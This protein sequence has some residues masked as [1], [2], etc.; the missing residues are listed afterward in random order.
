[1][2]V[3]HL[4]RL[5]Q[6]QRRL[7]SRIATGA[8]VCG[9][10]L[11]LA[12]RANA[13]ADPLA[14]R[15]VTVEAAGEFET[16][17]RYA[18]TV[19]ARRASQLGFTQPG[20]VAEVLVDVGDRVI[21]GAVLARLL[22]D[23]VKA[24]LAESRAAL[25]LARANVVAAEADLELAQETASR[26]RNLHER[27]H[28][29]A[30]TYDEQRLGAAAARARRDVAVAERARAQAALDVAEVRL[31]QTE[32]R[33]PYDGMV[34]ARLADEGTQVNP[35]NVVLR[36][37]ELDRQ[38]AH[39]GVP[40]QLANTLEPGADAELYWGN[41]RLSV[42]LRAVLPEIDP[43]TRTLTAIYELTGSEA[44]LP[45]GAVV[46]L[47]LATAVESSGNWVP[48]AALTE[49]ERGL[50]GVYVVAADDT[51]DRRLVEILHTES[52]RV[53]VRGT[54]TSGDRIVAEGVHRLVP[55]QRVR[56]QGTELALSRPGITR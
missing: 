22:Q 56:V 54:L 44:R 43:T 39:V 19:A 21:A 9:A 12:P 4:R 17:R 49:S 13:S 50:W 46:E 48:L 38:E 41:E 36:L 6:R 14:V 16:R 35:A 47:G 31:R 1:M 10:V 40:D 28:A 32:I 26:F 11:L 45:I 8:L 34:Q 29:S 33:A 42:R 55:G 23:D 27:G 52:D 15:V 53:F 51:L 20:E 5:P 30:Q 2:H 7:L 3:L 18:G 25:T 24:A 37:V